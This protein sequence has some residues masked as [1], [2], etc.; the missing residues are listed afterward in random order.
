[1]IA[2]GSPPLMMWVVCTHFLEGLSRPIPGM[3]VMFGAVLLNALLNWIFIF[4]NLGGP[5]MGAE[6]A[7]IATSLVRW[8]HVRCAAARSAAPPRCP[9]PRYPP[10]R[11]RLLGDLGNGSGA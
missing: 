10:A 8:G 5:E 2:W 11:C 4:G 9:R 3:L 6:G 7:A 1:M